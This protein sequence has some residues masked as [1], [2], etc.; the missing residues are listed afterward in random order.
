MPNGILYGMNLAVDKFG[1]VILPKPV[2]ER[3]HLSPGSGLTLEELPDGVVLRIIRNQPALTRQSGLLVHTGKA[4]RSLDWSRVVENAREADIA[5]DR[6]TM[7]GTKD[8]MEP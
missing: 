3:L 2:R 1:R 4:I 5:V 8:S 6:D 7:S